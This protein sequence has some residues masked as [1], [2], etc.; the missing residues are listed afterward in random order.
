[1]PKTADFLAGSVAWLE[2][3]FLS[4]SCM[5]L[6]SSGL[7]GQDNFFIP[8][9]AILHMSRTALAAVSLRRGFPPSSSLIRTRTARPGSSRL[10]L[11][12]VGFV[13]HRTSRLREHLAC[14]V[15]SVRCVPGTRRPFS[16]TNV[17]HRMHPLHPTFNPA[18]HGTALLVTNDYSQPWHAV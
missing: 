15:P 6:L 1:M 16:W 8:G 9:S 2:K 4:H 11:M 14:L 3:L 17:V 18:L 12:I 10:T 7:S 13:W 5:A